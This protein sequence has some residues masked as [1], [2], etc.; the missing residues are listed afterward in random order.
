MNKRIFF[1]LLPVALLLCA[2][3]VIFYEKSGEKISDNDAS[4]IPKKSSSSR[5]GNHGKENDI[6]S[7][8]VEANKVSIKSDGEVFLEELDQ[9]KNDNGSVKLFKSFSMWLK[10]DPVGALAALNDIK[11]EKIKYILIMQNLG[12]CKKYPE[13]I[14]GHVQSLSNPKYKNYLQNQ[15]I[16]VLTNHSDDKAVDI[17]VNHVAPGPEK[18]LMLQ[19]FFAVITRADIGA[20]ISS[21][22]KFRH[23]EDLT[24]AQQT[25]TE[26]VIY[27]NPENIKT[28]IEQNFPKQLL[29]DGISRYLG[30]SVS[31]GIDYPIWF[32]ELPLEYR[33]GVLSSLRQ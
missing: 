31:D 9:I 19:N 13:E 3:S 7:T 6:F 20:A 32:D 2:G 33:N 22:A 14:F 16:S 5:S 30:E 26:E 21:L 1:V 29:I 23:L 27:N 28:L 25:I 17:I 11:M 24:L 12:M 15:F 4:N 10:S 18:N 8:D